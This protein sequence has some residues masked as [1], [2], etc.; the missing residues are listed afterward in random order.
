MQALQ[1]ARHADRALP[2]PIIF[3]GDILP[4]QH[5]IINS[6]IGVQRLLIYVMILRLIFCVLSIL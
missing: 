3:A 5:T 2:L 6:L 4:H 1:P